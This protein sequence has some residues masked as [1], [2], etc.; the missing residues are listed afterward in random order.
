MTL[1]MNKVGI[2][3]SGILLLGV[4]PTSSPTS[5]T[6]PIEF[7]IDQKTDNPNVNI[8]VGNKAAPQDVISAT[9]LTSKIGTMVYAEK[10]IFLTEEYDPIHY[11][12][13]PLL[14]SLEKKFDFDDEAI[15]Q[16]MYL[17]FPTLDVPD[18]SL[19]QEWEYNATSIN[20][21]LGSLWYFDDNPHAFWGNNDEKFQPW[22]THEEIQTRFDSQSD[23]KND[24]FLTP[25]D[26]LPCLYGEDI[27]LYKCDE[28]FGNL[29]DGYI[30]PGLIY[31]ADNI[32]VPPMVSIITE[33]KSTI[34][35]SLSD[36]DLRQ[37]TNLFVPEPWMVLLN[38]LPSFKLFNEIHT[39][40]DA[41]PMLDLNIITNEIGNLHG[42]PY[43]V[44]GQPT[45]ETQIYLYKNKPIK[46]PSCTI[47]LIEVDIDNNEAFIEVF[48]QGELLDSFSMLLNSRNGFSPNPKQKFSPFSTYQTWNDRNDNGELDSGEFTN[49]ETYDIDHDGIFDC[50]RWVVDF[51]QE[52]I[53]VGY[54]WIYYTDDQNNPWALFNIP[55]IAID[56]VRIFADGKGIGMEIK[57]YWLENEKIWYNQ[58]CSDP[59][60]TQVSNYQQFLDAYEVGWDEINANKYIY[61]PP[62]TGLW[63]PKG[64][65]T[66]TKKA[67]SKI[68]V[69]DGF[70]DNN[71]GH[72]GCEYKYLTTN[73]PEA[74]F[75]E[76]NDLDRDGSKTND[77]R[78]DNW[79]LKANCTNL[80][81]IEDPV[82]W[83]GPGQ[84]LMELNIF[85][86]DKLCAPIYDYK[87]A[88]S[89]PYLADSP[90]FTIEVTDIAFSSGDGDGIDYNIFKSGT[91]EGIVIDT[92]SGIDDLDLIM[93]DEELDFAGWKTICDKNLILIGGPVANSIVRRLV[94]IYS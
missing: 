47:E 50:N 77:C 11:E 55:T 66:W 92:L 54:K 75:P 63:P 33:Y 32:F 88:I 13:D 39:V 43:L 36:V 2:I 51:V 24:L 37:Y 28:E 10:G 4:I 44:T 31:R 15:A 18:S 19:Y 76:Q 25:Q 41:G 29:T 71:D 6:P 82:V 93:L 35:N 74:Y 12:I 84:I 3:L 60:I 80:Y 69:G 5:N 73:V 89:G 9:L 45:F 57:A 53:W 65:N 30:L 21:T 23:T 64:L 85:L 61:Q 26:H 48:N 87:W 34:G 20:Y 59:W 8:I 83:H 62:G 91:V 14:F 56:G 1:K 17:G 79:S 86:C 68:L 49:I 78:N 40:I 90:Y 52:D 27:R 16:L 67:D 38:R 94:H 7:F 72:I 70:L 22:E 81:D 46:F 42:T 58:F